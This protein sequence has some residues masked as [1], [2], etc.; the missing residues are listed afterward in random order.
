MSTP[1]G[2]TGGGGGTYGAGGLS[3]TSS[4]TGQ[5]R[6]KGISAATKR[7]AAATSGGLTST[8]SMGNVQ[9]V[10]AGQGGSKS[11]EYYS[12]FAGPAPNPKNPN[13][14]MGADSKIAFMDYSDAVNMYYQWDAKTKNKFLSQL[15]LAGYDT[16]TMR[17]ADIAKLWS[18]YVGVA[19]QYQ[20]N[21]K[22]ISPWDV[23][24]K[25]I[26]QR[27][28]AA[29]QPRTINQTQKAYNIS[30]AED[31]AALF[32]G[33]AQTLL[34]RDPTKAE[35]ARF[36]SVLTKYEQ[37]N[38]AT[39]TTTSTYLGQDLQSQSSTTTGGVDAAAQQYIAEQ[40]AKKNPEYG[41]YQAATNGM[42]WLMQ[43]LGG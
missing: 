43:M 24:G 1:T 19:A 6:T 23:L 21:G 9:Y 32:Q 39:T 4:S 17:D 37:A 15:A 27:S 29:S 26:A 42:N 16:S 8:S 20:T 34:G 28:A 30:T 41:A 31:A 14:W 18:G 13:L 10:P 7:V 25:D 40:E 35:Q 2:G 38:P 3:D 33:A 12:R 36:K 5:S 11:D 22:Q